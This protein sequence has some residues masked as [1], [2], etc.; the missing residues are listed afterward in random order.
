M[1]RLCSICGLEYEN[2]EDCPICD[3]DNSTHNQREN[4]EYCICD[5]CKE[6]IN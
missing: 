4:C 5:D 1:N 3:N 6:D 2:E